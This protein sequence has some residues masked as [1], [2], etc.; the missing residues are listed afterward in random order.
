LI[1]ILLPNWLAA[2]DYRWIITY[3]NATNEWNRKVASGENKVVLKAQFI[4]VTA[5]D[6]NLTKFAVR[7]FSDYTDEWLIDSVQLWK[8]TD[9]YPGSLDRE[10]DSLI[11]QKDVSINPQPLPTN[12]ITF[13][14]AGSELVLDDTTTFFVTM[15]FT[16]YHDPTSDN[17]EITDQ[18]GAQ[19]GITIQKST[20]DLTVTPGATTSNSWAGSTTMYYELRAVNLPIVVY[21]KN[22]SSAEDSVRFY[23]HYNTVSALP[24]NQGQ[25]MTDLTFSAYINLPHSN[26]QIIGEEDRLSYASFK[27]GWDNTILQL[28]SLRFGDIWQGKAYSSDGSGF[29]QIETGSTPKYSIVR[30]EGLVWGD[31][32]YVDID[33]NNLAILDFKVIKP[34]ISPIFL[35][36]ITVI[37]QWGIPYHV[38][39]NLYNDTESATPLYDAWAKFIVGDVVASVSGNLYNGMGDGRV[40]A[41]DITLFSNH[42]W[43]NPDSAD[44]YDRF[45]V[46]S[47]NS[48]DP[49][50]ISPDDTTNFYDLMVL[51]TNYFRSYTGQFAQ[52]RASGQNPLTITLQVEKPIVDDSEY[53]VNLDLQN[54][55]Q[56]ASAQFKL[57]FDPA[58][59]EFLELQPGE[60]TRNGSPEHLLIYYEPSLANGIIDINFLALTNPLSG[61]GEFATIRLKK[62]APSK[63]SPGA[64]ALQ[65]ES[66]D[67]R[68]IAGQ[69]IAMQIG[70]S[71]VI[72]PEKFLTLTNYPNPFNATTAIRFNIPL[73][74]A[75]DYILRIYDLR[76]NLVRTLSSGQMPAGGYYLI[77]DGKNQQGQA[78]VSGI[79]LLSLKSKNANLIRKITL[80]R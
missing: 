29:G 64:P 79:Y 69:Q 37:D 72:L 12:A 6:Y 54:L 30:F 28:D 75:G 20:T 16:D 19:F 48:H 47:V 50:E 78:A 35:S 45:D 70:A 63:L 65:I 43:L 14:L 11:S 1:F 22:K 73:D 17:L 58:D 74:L 13:D 52:K 24:A 15:M 33:E 39:Q 9:N 10:N 41:D 27:V 60:L 44:W 56:L 46:G 42:I 21:N 32:N 76:G 49:D 57:R 34:G 77:W 68:D 59:I 26:L 66:A 18:N 53:I 3:P 23:P 2:E 80:I 71:A 31:T 5:G 38:Y 40:N 55:V 7:P 62:L 61:D 4:K 25:I 36:D 51:G 67:C 8:N